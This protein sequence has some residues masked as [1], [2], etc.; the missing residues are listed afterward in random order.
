MNAI[1][2]PPTT[3][4]FDGA[5]PVCSREIAHYRTRRGADALRFVDVAADPA[6]QVAPDLTRQAAL[7]RMHVRR[8]D[9]E[10]VSGAAAFAALWRSLPGWAWLGRLIAVPPMLWL[11]ERGYRGFQRA[12]RLG[13]WRRARQRAMAHRA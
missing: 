4:Y 5:C 3:V 11:A 12:R 13:P 2:R 10:L 6:E 7:D 8:P 9:G 1:T